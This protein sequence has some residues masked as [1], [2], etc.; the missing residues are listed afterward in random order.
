MD[1]SELLPSSETSS[2][3]QELINSG[4]NE[5]GSTL[6]KRDISSGYSLGLQSLGYLDDEQENSN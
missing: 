1:L 4:Q 6:E 3:E 2:Q 5:P